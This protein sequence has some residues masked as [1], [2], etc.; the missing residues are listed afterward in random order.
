MTNQTESPLRSDK[1]ARGLIF[2]II[3]QVITV[4]VSLY[5]LSQLSVKLDAQAMMSQGV[6]PLATVIGCLSPLVYIFQI[7]AL[8]HLVQD[9]RRVGGLHRRF[10]I[11]A[12][13]AYPLTLFVGLV[14]IVLSF[15]I[16]TQGS[17]DTFRMVGWANMVSTSLAFIALAM[18][19]YSI[20]PNLARL[21]LIAAVVLVVAGTVGSS[22]M[23][24][25]NVT[26]ESYDMMGNTY[27][28]PNT[29]LNRAEGLYPI[30]SVAVLIGNLLYLVVA[31]WLVLISWKQAGQSLPETVS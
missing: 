2:L 24:L 29:N 17:V 10:S 7:I 4:A 26:F 25:Q 15:S 31:A 6:D 9:S 16:T 11:A 28:I 30:L 1:L 14:T 13:W 5:G 19:I 20:S 23:S 8:V 21:A 27:Y 18:L 22:V 12:A 3:A